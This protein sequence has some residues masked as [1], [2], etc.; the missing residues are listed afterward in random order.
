MY[1][2]A[3]YVNRIHSVLWHEGYRYYCM[4]VCVP[5]DAG[6]C[7]WCRTS[8]YQTGLRTNKSY[9]FTRR[10]GA[11]YHIDVIQA[12]FP[13]KSMCFPHFQRNIC[14]YIY[15][16]TRTKTNYKYKLNC[17]YTGIKKEMFALHVN[18]NRKNL[19]I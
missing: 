13:T 8:C 19:C 11:W 3:T 17:I 1:V 14:V 12:Y 9:L 18:Y 4:E 16:Y 7:A 2:Y 6:T 10:L 5:G 15:I